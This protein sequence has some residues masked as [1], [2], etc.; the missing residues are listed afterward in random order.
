MRMKIRRNF[1]QENR[2]PWD[3]SFGLLHDIC[4]WAVDP[5]FSVFERFYKLISFLLSVRRYDLCWVLWLL[6][7]RND[8]P[9]TNYDHVFDSEHGSGIIVYSA[10]R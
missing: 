6:M 4:W 8:T 5:G 10:R 9:L 7:Y 2:R 1:E 3:R